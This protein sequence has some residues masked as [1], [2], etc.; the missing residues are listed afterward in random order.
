MVAQK[1]A[2]RSEAVQIPSTYYPIPTTKK[3]VLL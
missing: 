2:Q 3:P 1:T